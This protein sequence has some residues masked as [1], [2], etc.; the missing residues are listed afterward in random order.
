M[1]PV[2]IFDP[3]CRKKVLFVKQTGKFAFG[4]DFELYQPYLRER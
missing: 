2:T 3:S 4:D 1:D